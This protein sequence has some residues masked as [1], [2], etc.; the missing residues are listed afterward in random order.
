MLCALCA[1]CVARGVCVADGVLFLIAFRSAESQRI[2]LVF[3][4]TVPAATPCIHSEPRFVGRLLHH[5][6]PPL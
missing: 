5:T 1:L 4:Y 3:V 6:H 2:V